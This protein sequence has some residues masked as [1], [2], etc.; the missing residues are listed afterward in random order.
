VKYFLPL[1]L[2]VAFALSACNTLN[3]RRSMYTNQK[4]HGPYTRQLEEGT[5]GQSKTVSE[6]YAEQ[7]RV[8][9]GPKLIPGQKASSGSSTTSSGPTGTQPAPDTA[10]P[11]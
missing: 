7:Q 8:K 3:N 6:Q 2:L 4:V 1:V 9:K 10:L 5:W 11:Q